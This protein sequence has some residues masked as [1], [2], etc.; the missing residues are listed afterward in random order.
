M[1]PRAFCSAC[2]AA[3]SSDMRLRTSSTCARSKSQGPSRSQVFGRSQG[4]QGFSPEFQPWQAHR[5][6]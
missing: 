3:S 4:S 5:I 1:A 6:K 2:S